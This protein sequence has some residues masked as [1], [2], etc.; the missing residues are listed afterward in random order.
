MSQSKELKGNNKARQYIIDLHKKRSFI[1]MIA[2]FVSIIL[3]VYAITASLVLYAK[4]GMRPIDLFQ[5][6]TIDANALTA[7]SATMILPFAIEGFRKKRFYCPKWAVYFYYVGVTCTTMIML[8][9]TFVISM[10]DLENAFFGYNFYMHIV[11]PI[12][13]LITFFLIESYYKITLKTSVAAITPVFIYALVYV[14]EV[15]IVGEEAGGWKDMYYFANNPVFSFCSMMVVTFAVAV[16][17]AF[18]Y[19]K[20]SVIRAKKIV[21]NLWDDGVSDVEIKIEVFGLGRFMGK[22]DNK[23]YATLPLDLIFII[24]D[25]YHIDRE[26]LIRVYVRGMLDSI[27]EKNSLPK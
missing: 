12:M 5:Y 2:S 22:E 9:A 4:N 7:L 19:N 14:Y 15:I 18:I 3:A 6:F 23:S 1:A 24:A 16:L 26:D 21:D 11:C 20:I 27:D 8:F 25:K 13:I 10:V 17:I